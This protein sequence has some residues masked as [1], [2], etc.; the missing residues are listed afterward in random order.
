MQW[1]VPQSSGLTMVSCAL[2][3]R[4][5]GTYRLEFSHPAA[6]Q[7][8]TFFGRYIEVVPNARIVW[9][10]EEHAEGAITTVTFQE[11]GAGTLLIIHDLFP[12]KEALDNEIASGATG[13]MAETLGQLHAFI[14]G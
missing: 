8:M 6:T 4:T 12:S 9:T 7:T 5:G 13:G 10:N 11:Q 1:W 3:V 14:A 2:D